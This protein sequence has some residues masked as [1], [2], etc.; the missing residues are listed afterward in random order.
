MFKISKNKAEL[1]R[2]FFTNP[3]NSYYMQEIGKIIGKK[4]GNFQRTLYNMSEQ[5]I[6]N[7]E[8]KGNLRF[9]SA[10][11]DYPLFSEIKGIVFK[12]VGISGSIKEILEKIGDINFSFIF[13]SY[14]SNCENLLS[15]IDLFLIGNPDEDKLIKKLDM[16]E[17][18]LKREINYKL[19]SPNYFDEAI[20]E[21][22]PFIINILKNKKIML[23]GNEDE[24][25]KI[26]KRK[27]DKKANTRF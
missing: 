11:K 14:A 8:Y 2:L 5:G 6:L 23:I 19:Y 4:P 26:I 13:G 24:F 17:E 7:S 3:E 25:G 12:T 1:L 9:F 15:D 10:N 22:E 16:L 20:K 21:K 27:P 18:L